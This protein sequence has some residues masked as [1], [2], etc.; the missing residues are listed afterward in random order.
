MNIQN[1]QNL[2]MV[3]PSHLLVDEEQL[4]SPGISLP[5]EAK[6]AMVHLHKAPKSSINASNWF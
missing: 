1:E 3:Q 5:K 4:L 6:I 2:L